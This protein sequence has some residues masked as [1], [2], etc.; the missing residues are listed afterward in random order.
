[1]GVMIS[2]DHYGR[3]L[4]CPEG[5]INKGLINLSASADRNELIPLFWQNLDAPEIAQRQ[6]SNRKPAWWQKRSGGAAERRGISGLGVHGLA[7]MPSP[8]ALPTHIEEDEDAV[9]EDEEDT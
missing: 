7:Y 5:D 9:E 2:T 3:P 6:L 4:F 1:M 8:G